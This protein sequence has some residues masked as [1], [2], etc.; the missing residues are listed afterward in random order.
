MCVYIIS[1]YHSIYPSIP[2][3]YSRVVVKQYW[4]D[5]WVDALD[6]DGVAATGIGRR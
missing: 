1:L 4:M 2:P 5:G 6:D 3:L